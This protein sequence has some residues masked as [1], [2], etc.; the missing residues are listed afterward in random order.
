VSQR[1]ALIDLGVVLAVVLE[2]VGVVLELVPRMTGSDAQLLHLVP[3][4]RAALSGGWLLL[5]RLF[6]LLDVV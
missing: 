3:C 5:A 6:R 4:H 1:A 2:R